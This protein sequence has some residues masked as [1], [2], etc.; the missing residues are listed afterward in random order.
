MP[1]GSS[2]TCFQTSSYCRAKVDFNSINLVRHG[3]NTTFQTG[4]SR[5]E[6][7]YVSIDSASGIIFY[8]FVAN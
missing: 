5:L 2:T 3:S 6:F 1:Q 7:V 8:D 4:L